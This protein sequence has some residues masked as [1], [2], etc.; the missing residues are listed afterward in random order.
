MVNNVSNQKSLTQE[1]VEFS[2]KL[3]TSAWLLIHFFHSSLHLSCNSNIYQYLNVFPLLFCTCF[4]TFSCTSGS[5]RSTG[6]ERARRNPRSAGGVSQ[7]LEAGSTQLQSCTKPCMCYYSVLLEARLHTCL[8]KHQDA[9]HLKASDQSH[10]F[11]S[12]RTHHASYS[13]NYEFIMALIKETQDPDLIKY[14]TGLWTLVCM[15]TFSE[16]QLQ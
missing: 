16:R 14:S 10:H 8:M 5:T 1:R 12:V 11:L 9:H 3:S 2:F 15:F 7:Y 6:K 4:N 13:I